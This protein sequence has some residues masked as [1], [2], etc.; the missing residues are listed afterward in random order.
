MADAPTPGETG[1]QNG[2]GAA[3]ADGDSNE[4]L[5]AELEAEQ[6]GDKPA[7]AA[8]AK[9]AKKPVADESDDD[10]DAD[11]DAA[12]DDDAAAADEGDDQDD[13]PA[14]EDDDD[15]EAGEAAAAA[16]DP[17]LAKRLA[18]ARRTEQR[19]RESLARDRAAFERE[20]DEWKSQTKTVTEG[21]QRFERLASR[22]KY[23]SY[24]LLREL[25]VPDEDM[26]LH[27][28][29]L[30]ARSKAA[31]VK[32]EHR[33][34]ADRALRDRELAD[35]VKQAKA[36]VKELKEGLTA[37]QQKAAADRELDVYFRR[38]VRKADDTA[39]RVKAL[40]AASPAR[41][42]AELEQTAYELAQKLGRLPKPAAVIAAHEKKVARQ[43]RD[44]GV[45]TGAEPAA[46]KPVPGKPGA[47][48]VAAAAKPA[49]KP[50]KPAAKPAPAAA[51][52]DDDR[53]G[54]VVHPSREQLL[55]ELRQ[56]QLS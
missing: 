27:A 41:A 21:Q 53:S 39:P 17:E 33:A 3:A 22:A 2:A 44:Y 30:Y 36:E 40:V 51:D 10:V 13:E 18:I 45:E 25:G 42:R 19:Q 38:V 11:D 50:G 20:R 12:D 5:L 34:A 6:A 55:R 7:A 46:A 48:P 23:D 43:L 32:P 26:E 16:A 1:D 37:Q 49:A 52:D 14:D 8:P 9:P 24:S 28:Q 15:G 47:K 4:A 29:H 54:E 35:E 31:A 56:E